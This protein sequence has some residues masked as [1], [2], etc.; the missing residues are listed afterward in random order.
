ME[1]HQHNTIQKLWSISKGLQLFIA[2][3]MSITPL[4]IHSC[5]FLQEVDSDLFFWRVSQFKIVQI[6]QRLCISCSDKIA[7]KALLCSSRFTMICSQGHE[8]IH[9]IPQVRGCKAKVGASFWQASLKPHHHGPGLPVLDA[10]SWQTNENN[11]KEDMVCI[12]P[13]L[14][15]KSSN[16]FKTNLNTIWSLSHVICTYVPWKEDRFSWT[17]AINQLSNCTGS[18]VTMPHLQRRRIQSSYQYMG[19]A[20]CAFSLDL[21]KWLR[22]ALFSKFRRLPLQ[23]YILDHFSNTTWW[24]VAILQPENEV[25]NPL[26]PHAL[27]E[28]YLPKAPWPLAFCLVR[29]CQEQHVLLHWPHRSTQHWQ[30]REVYW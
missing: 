15:T 8:S 2:E 6:I 7:P 1:K 18:Q 13:H 21:S 3:M 20:A 17:L 11:M 24:W 9:G 30:I 23:N 25:A 16:M 4:C 29:A 19:V 10:T 26:T 14:E 22:V 28:P 5:I 27:Q 12:C